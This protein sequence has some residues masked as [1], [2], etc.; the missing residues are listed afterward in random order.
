MCF[1]GFHFLDN[2]SGLDCEVTSSVKEARLRHKQFQAGLTPGFSYIDMA[3]PDL[4]SSHS[5][6]VSIFRR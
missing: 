2:F 1:V 3:E 4:V 5:A 6:S